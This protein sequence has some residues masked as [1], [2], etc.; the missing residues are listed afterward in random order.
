M[1]YLLLTILIFLTGCSLTG[2]VTLEG[3]F[4]VTNVVD[5]DTLDLNNGDRIRFSGI[6][7]PET[8]ECYYQEAKDFLSSLVLNKNVFIE[9]D[10]SD[11]GK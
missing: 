4:T 3:P 5:G 1:K 6:N 9:K 11:E 8:G 7:T 10:K 2:N